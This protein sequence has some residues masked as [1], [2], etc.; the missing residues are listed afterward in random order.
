LG[1]ACLALNDL[2]VFVPLSTFNQGFTGFSKEIG[3][4]TAGLEAIAKLDARTY[5]AFASNKSLCFH[6]IFFMRC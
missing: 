2:G 5:L 6:N 1:G 4:T 3:T